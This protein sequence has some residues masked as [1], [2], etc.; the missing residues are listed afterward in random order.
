MFSNTLNIWRISW[1]KSR[2]DRANF[3]A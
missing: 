1:R 3:F 2:L